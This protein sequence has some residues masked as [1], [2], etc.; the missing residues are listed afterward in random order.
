MSRETETD[1]SPWTRHAL[2]WGKVGSPLRPVAE[3]AEFYWHAITSALPRTE[4]ARAQVLLLGAT[5]ELASMPWPAGAS[6]MACDLSLD[7]L[8]GVWPLGRFPGTLAAAVNA[9]WLA[10]P[11]DSGSCSVV[12]GDG[13][14]S[15]MSR[16]ADFERISLELH[17]VLQPSGLLVLRLFCQPAVAE[18]PESVLADLRRG[19][20]GS[21]HAYKWR[22]VMAIHAGDE[23]ASL[24]DVWKVWT[25]E[26]P[27]PDQVR[28]LSG[29]PAEAIQTPGA[30]RGAS[31]RYSFFRLAEVRAMLSAEFEFIDAV[32]P[33]YELG[34]R[35]PVASFR[36]RAR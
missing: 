6:L 22:L 30:Y 20:V 28:A 23:N 2:Q 11:L 3:D 4:L 19:H 8:R 7:M 9:N 17:R 31:A 34:E 18:L 10:L 36:R 15:V 1:A 26:F 25:T 32:W 5:P 16:V 35:C 13:S 29:W 21:F 27:D 14:L 33:T 12:I 24:D